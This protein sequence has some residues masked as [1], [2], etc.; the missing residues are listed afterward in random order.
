MDGMASKAVSLRLKCQGSWGEVRQGCASCGV[1]N[2]THKEILLYR[3][4]ATDEN[5]HAILGWRDGLTFLSSGS[6]ARINFSS[7]VGTQNHSIRKVDALLRP[8]VRVKTKHGCVSDVLN[9]M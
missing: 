1:E 4:A 2:N 7:Q 9:C 8:W 3:G 6:S 5:K